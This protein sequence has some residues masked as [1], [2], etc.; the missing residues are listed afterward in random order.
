M[1]TPTDFVDQPVDF[2]GKWHPVRGK[3]TINDGAHQFNGHDDTEN[4][5]ALLLY[6]VPLSDGEIAAELY[7]LDPPDEAQDPC[8]HIVFHFAGNVDYC[9]AGIGGWESH[10]A[11]G[12]KTPP[13]VPGGD[14][15]WERLKGDGRY[16]YM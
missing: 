2:A 10:Y 15:G 5:E 6:E 9:V 13:G 1:K 8:A 14:P 7:V 16:E 11:I 4:P 3:W 12:R